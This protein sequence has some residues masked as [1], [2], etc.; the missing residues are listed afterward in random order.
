[1]SRIP[2]PTPSPAKKHDEFKN[3]ILKELQR[4]LA[5][6]A[7]HSMRTSSLKDK[8]QLKEKIS[9]KNV[10]DV[11]RKISNLGAGP[12]STVR[13]LEAKK[14]WTWTQRLWVQVRAQP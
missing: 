12:R 7:Y 3:D 11:V 8:Q 1:M 14:T 13:R 5:A 9:L 10:S 2:T 6:C 4:Y